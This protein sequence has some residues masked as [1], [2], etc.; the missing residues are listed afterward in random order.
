MSYEEE[1]WCL[2][3]SGVSKDLLKYQILKVNASN[4]C[5]TQGTKERLYLVIALCPFYLLSHI[6]SV[7]YTKTC[8]MVVL[9]F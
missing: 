7:H 8:M 4:T 2:L 9:A 6:Y 3:A 5:S 1:K